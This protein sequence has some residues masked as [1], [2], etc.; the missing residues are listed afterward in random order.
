MVESTIGALPATDGWLER[1][2]FG[3]E[4]LGAL[5]LR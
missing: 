5:Y 1:T 2:Y 4:F 3:V